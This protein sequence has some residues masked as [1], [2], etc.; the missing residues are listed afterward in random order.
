MVMQPDVLAVQ[1][2]RLVI[3]GGNEWNWRKRRKA[4]AFVSPPERRWARL[5]SGRD[6]KDSLAEAIVSMDADGVTDGCGKGRGS[7][8]II[9]PMISS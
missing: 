9:A 6:P 1:H 7:V 8:P 3:N 2:V 4:V 5:G